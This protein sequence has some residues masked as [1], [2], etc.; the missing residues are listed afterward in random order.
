MWDSLEC[1]SSMLLC[2]D[3]LLTQPI[4]NFYTICR[5]DLCCVF[6]SDVNKTKCLQDQDQDQ[7][8]KTKTT[9]RPLHMTDL[10]FK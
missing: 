10:T 7:N 8:N 1:Q 2:F 5:A 9:G 3:S 4:V 6:V